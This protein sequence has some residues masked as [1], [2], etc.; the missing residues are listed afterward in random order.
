MAIGGI[1]QLIINSAFREPSGHWKYDLQTQSFIREEGRRP[2]GYFVAGQGSNQYNNIGQFIELPLVNTIR[3]RVKAWREKGYSGVTGTTKKLL[4][5]WN[6]NSARQ[7]QFFFCQMDAIET[8]IWLVEA[9]EVEKVGIDIKDDGGLFKRICTKI[10]TGGGKTTVMAMLIAWQIINKVT[11]PKDK[12]FSKNVFIVAP[13]LTVKR[14]LQVLN[15][16]GQGNYYS[17]FNIVPFSL[18]DKLRQGKV[19]IKNW[20]TLA[21]DTEEKIAKKK[22]VDKRGAKSDEAYTREVLDDL[23]NASSILVINDEA[24]HAWRKNPQIKVKLT[25]EEKELEQQA[26]VWVGGLDRIHKTRKILTCYDFSATPFAPSGKKNDEEA[27]FSW[28]VSDFGL[29][30]GIE[31][32]LVKTPRV[33]VRDDVVP[34]TES[35]KSKL[36]HIYAD[37]TVKD[38]INRAALPE[39][40]LPDLLN[41]AYY[42]LGKDWLELYLSWKEQGSVIPPVMITVANRT[43]TAARIKY[44]F[45]HKRIPIEGLC[46]PEYTIHIDSKTMEAAEGE[47]SYAAD[48]ATDKKVSKKDAAIILRDTVDTVGQRG[49]RGEQIRNVISVG[50]LSEGWDAKTVTHIMGLRAFSSQ[51]LCE[52]VVGRGLRRTSYDLEEGS[53]KFTAEYVNIFGIPFTFLPH[54]SEGEGNAPTTPPKTQIEALKDKIKYRIS[55]PNIIRIDREMKLNLSI[56]LSKIEPLVLE[57]SETRLKADL[58]PIVDG[59]TDLLRCTE[60]DLEKIDRKLRM[61][62]IVFEAAGQVYDLMQ[63]SCSWQNKGTKFALLGQVINLVDK[64]LKSDSIQINPALFNTEPVRQRIVMMLNMNKIVQHLW[65]FIK[66]E[67]TKKIIPVFDKSKKVL[68]TEDMNTWFTSKPC[69]ITNKSHISHVVY[70][71]AWEATTAYKFEKNDNVAAWVKNDHLGF[72]IFYIFDGVVRKY[73]PDFL[74]KLTNGKM[75]VLE[76]KGQETR[77]DKEKRKALTE[78]IHAVN[79]CGE[80]GEWYNDVSYNVADVDGIIAKY[81]FSTDSLQKNQTYGISLSESFAEYYTNPEFAKLI[82]SGNF[83]Y[84]S[85]RYV[86]SDSKYIKNSEDGRLDLTDYAKLHLDECSLLFELNKESMVGA[87]YPAAEGHRKDILKCKIVSKF[88]SNNHNMEMFARS[89]ELKRFHDEFVEESKHLSSVNQSF[90]KAVYGHIQRK[91]Y[92][93]VIFTDKTLLSEKTFDRIKNNQLN[94]PNLETV[95]AICIGLELSPTYCEE[96][97]KIAGF[98]LNHSRQQLAY[99]KILYSFR[100]HSICECNEVLAALDLPLICARAYKEM[101][102]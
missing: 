3:T 51:L 14:R 44:A 21:W 80:Y 87:G 38:D 36:Y 39:E 31:S 96:L 82:D 73:T 79:A 68:G 77:R 83:V 2:A 85:G 9:P 88:N 5:H 60:I 54:E 97:L 67:Q 91:G 35:F 93:K 89:E 10:C 19:V 59:Q 46:N 24:H 16:G 102:E 47:T 99:R 98:T 58:A 12:R 78:W 76:T 30:D 43:E 8:L 17:Q 64:Y 41:Q 6:D 66:L 55:W 69:S 4:E 18:I 53:D 94:Q 63:S 40:P 86:I 52:Q 13:G 90:S 1:D 32:G 57:A 62:K 72:E 27:L 7:Y 70:D 74:I 101:T 75:L 92:N 22:T 45:D 25:K 50:M 11:Y 42:L 71:S 49:E 81:A 20:Q 65:S 56:D 95:M 48:E 33:V 84:V 34:N 26:T 61:Q 23:A 100:G 15:V 37:D 29:N 28:I